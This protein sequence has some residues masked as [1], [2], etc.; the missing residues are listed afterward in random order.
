M[1][2]LK[3]TVIRSLIAI[4][5]GIVLIKWP[6]LAPNMI[7]IIIGI[8]FIIPGIATLISYWVRKSKDG[9]KLPSYILIESI[10]SILLGLCMT[11]IPEFFTGFFMYCLGFLLILGGIIQIISLANIPRNIQVSI[12]Y[13]ITPILILIAGIIT[14]LNPFET[15]DAILI[16]FGICTIIYGIS[17]LINYYKLR[18]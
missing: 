6:R 15:Q 10:G 4:I 11:L 13:Y 17:E 5:L 18:K 2:T 12:Y 14:V 3:N 8:L 1:N 9:M 7:I 16:M